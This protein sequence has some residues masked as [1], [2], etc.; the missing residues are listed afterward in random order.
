MRLGYSFA[1][2]SV[3]CA[4]VLGCGSTGGAERCAEEQ[5]IA[6]MKSITIPK[7]AVF[8]DADVAKVLQFLEQVSGLDE[9]GRPLIHFRRESIPPNPHQTKV[10][11]LFEQ[12]W[13]LYEAFRLFGS[14]VS[15]VWRIEGGTVVMVFIE[16]ESV[17]PSKAQELM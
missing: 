8:K 1:L 6:R 12:G 16:T 14:L 17:E 11:I 10:T 7:S 4:F 5:M 3:I 13:S 15:S 2:L 9:A